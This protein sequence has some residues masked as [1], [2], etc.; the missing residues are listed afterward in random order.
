MARINLHRAVLGPNGGH[1]GR[2]GTTHY[3]IQVV[4]GLSLRY[5]HGPIRPRG[6]A[7]M[8]QITGLTV[9]LV[10]SWLLQYQG[11]VGDGMIV[12]KEM[13]KL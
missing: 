9:A 7:S 11:Y 6:R 3:A 2:H 10:M 12:M 1:M 4:P 8:A 13:H 5:E